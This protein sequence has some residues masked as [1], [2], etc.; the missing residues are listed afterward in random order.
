MTRRARRYYR[1][2]FLGTAALGALIWGAVDQFGVPWEDMRELF[3]LTLLV[4][5]VVIGLAALMA[6]GWILL[7]KI[8]QGRG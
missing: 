1:T 7:R 5:L 6:A 2:L 8:L 4:M 3:L